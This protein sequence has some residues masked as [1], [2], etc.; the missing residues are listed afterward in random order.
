M[1]PLTH[2]VIAGLDPA[3]HSSVALAKPIREWIAGSTPAMTVERGEAAVA[4]LL[5]VKPLCL[6]VSVV[7]GQRLDLGQ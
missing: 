7:Q 5:S 3:I 1:F 6:C 2:I 4:T